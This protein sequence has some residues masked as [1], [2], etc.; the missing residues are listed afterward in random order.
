MCDKVKQVP[1]KFLIVGLKI[2]YL[3]HVNFLS[4]GHLER[5]FNEIWM[6]TYKSM[7][8]RQKGPTH[9]AYAWQIGPFWQDTL[10]MYFQ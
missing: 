3:N 5:N 1:S 6:K 8:S 4:V 10:E 7:V 9:H 2:Y